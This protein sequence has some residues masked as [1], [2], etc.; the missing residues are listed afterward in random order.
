M[1]VFF[2]KGSIIQLNK[3]KQLVHVTRADKYGCGE[4][5]FYPKVNLPSTNY[6]PIYVRYLCH[7]A[8]NESLG[9]KYEHKC[10]NII[11]SGYIFKEI[12]NKGGV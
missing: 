4:C 9:F 12:N 8:L 3:T 7:K 11:P 10:S 5:I 2:V 1:K 6:A